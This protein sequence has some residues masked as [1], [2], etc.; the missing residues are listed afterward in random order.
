MLLVKKQRLQRIPMASFPRPKH[1]CHSLSILP[2]DTLPGVAVRRDRRR[3]QGDDADPGIGGLRKMVSLRRH[4]RSGQDTDQPS[5]F[6]CP[7]ARAGRACAAHRVADGMVSPDMPKVRP[8]SPLSSGSNLKTGMRTS[9]APAAAGWSVADKLVRPGSIGSDEHHSGK[10]HQRDRS[11]RQKPLNG[12][13]KGAI[14]STLSRQLSAPRPSALKTNPRRGSRAWLKAVEAEFYLP[15]EGGGSRKAAGGG[16]C[17]GRPKRH[18]TPALR[19]DP[20]PQ[21]EGVYLIDARRLSHV[22]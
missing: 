4:G 6:R 10:P 12:V 15:L 17:L 9:E 8:I 2:S 20:P 22:R 5:R 16:D 3:V 14:Y 7:K 18:P 13:L 21:G 11:R 1:P 19:A